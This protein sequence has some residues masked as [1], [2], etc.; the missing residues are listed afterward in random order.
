MSGYTEP[1]YEPDTT[2]REEYELNWIRR[3]LLKNEKPRNLRYL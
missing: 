3:G 1:I 2:W